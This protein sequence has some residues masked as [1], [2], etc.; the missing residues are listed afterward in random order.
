MVIVHNTKNHRGEQSMDYLKKYGAKVVKNG[1]PI[2][3][4][5]NKSKKPIGFQWQSRENLC[6]WHF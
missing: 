2:V 5:P 6:I 4:L 3:L 1:W